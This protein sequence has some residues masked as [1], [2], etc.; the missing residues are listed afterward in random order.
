MPL[1]N[2]GRPKARESP[3]LIKKVHKQERV[4]KNVEAR[5]IS[6]CYIMLEAGKPNLFT[7]I[8]I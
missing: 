1:R 4:G 8:T 2:K 5:K 3:Q 6:S 7:V